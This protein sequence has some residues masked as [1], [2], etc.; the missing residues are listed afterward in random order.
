MNYTLF[1]NV[2]KKSK[3]DKNMQKIEVF[4]IYKI[5]GGRYRKTDFT[6]VFYASRRIFWY[7]QR[8]SHLPGSTLNPKLGVFSQRY[9]R[10]TKPQG[11]RPNERYAPG[12]LASSEA[13][14]IQTQR[15]T[16]YIRL[17]LKT[18]S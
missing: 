15:H 7:I 18:Y 13:A 5:R 10:P 4:C 17:K 3:L 12:L 14:I 9:L 6:I 8:R 2:C 11:F 1:C 16:E